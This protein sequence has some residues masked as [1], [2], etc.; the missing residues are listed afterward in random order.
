MVRPPNRAEFWWPT[1]RAEPS[2][3]A[4]PPS[5]RLAS[6]LR[7]LVKPGTPRTDLDGITLSR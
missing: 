1:L 2:C 3:R 7:F 4:E 6:R 5:S